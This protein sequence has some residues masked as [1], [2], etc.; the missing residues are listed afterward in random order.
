MTL[1]RT[2]IR[3]A[4]LVRLAAGRKVMRTPPLYI[5]LVILHTKYTGR[6]ENDFVVHGQARRGLR[7]ARPGL[8]RRASAIGLPAKLQP[9]A[10]GK[11]NKLITFASRT[12]CKSIL[13]YTGRTERA[14]APC[15]SRL[16]TGLCACLTSCPRVRPRVW[17][18]VTPMVFS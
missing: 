12:F 13:S 9:C 15:R 3:R 11:F 16:S 18:S 4:W 14:G 1:S 6:S 7:R 10:G 5:S 2:A 8:G 17:M